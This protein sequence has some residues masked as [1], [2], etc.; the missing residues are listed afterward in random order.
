[1]KATFAKYLLVIFLGSCTA[2]VNEEEINYSGF[3]EK[4][5]PIS[6]YSREKREK[7][8]VAILTIKIP[9][10]LDTSSQWQPFREFIRGNRR[11]HR[12]ADS[13]YSLVV[14]RPELEYYLQSADSLYQLTISYPSW[15]D[16]VKDSLPEK[17]YPKDTSSLI[18]RINWRELNFD[19][20]N[21]IF[22]KYLDQGTHSF[23]IA[24][25][26]TPSIYRENEMKLVLSGFTRIR[27]VHVIIEAECDAKDTTG[28]TDSMF[29]AFLSIRIKDNP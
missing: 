14:E 6:T 9:E 4:E 16:G 13:R 26:R 24:C 11:I 5:V 10:R 20:S 21:I 23:L 28:F 27:D 8:T 17:F 19:S 3:T 29:K 22:K 1:M 18:E 7:D 25:Y 2:S 12:F 15:S